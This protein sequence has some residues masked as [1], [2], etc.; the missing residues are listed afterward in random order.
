[1]TN[2]WTVN[3]VEAPEGRSFMLEEVSGKKVVVGVMCF[4]TTLTAGWL[5][6]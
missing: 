3:G 6:T 1:M 4:T 5:Q 2:K